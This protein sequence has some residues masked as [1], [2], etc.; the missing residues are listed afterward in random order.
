MYLAAEEMQMTTDNLFSGET[1]NRSMPA[2]TVIPVLQYPDVI[3]AAAWLCRVFGFTERLRIGNHRVQLSVG[4]AA[5]VIAQNSQPVSAAAAACISV[6]VRVRNADEHCR[7]SKLEGAG[8]I[9]Q[10]VSQPY[11]ERQYRVADLAGYGWTFSQTESDV[12]PASWGGASR[13]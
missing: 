4:D 13:S 10:P 6:M 2:A 12:D 11:G 8:I 9:E 1:T 5:V 7:H 3:A